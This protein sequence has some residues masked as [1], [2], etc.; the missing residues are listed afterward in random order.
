M[1]A[2][3]ATEVCTANGQNC[4][5]VIHILSP[6][7]RIFVKKDGN[8]KYSN[9]TVVTMVAREQQTHSSSTWLTFF[10]VIIL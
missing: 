3:H 8:R 6:K 7:A 4:K 2:V 1:N 5:F 10:L 9:S